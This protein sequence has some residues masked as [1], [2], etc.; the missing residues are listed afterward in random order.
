MDQKIK[1]EGNVDEDPDE[2]IPEEEKTKQ[3]QK[4][5]HPLLCLKMKYDTWM[6]EIPVIG[7][8]SGNY[9]INLIKP[10]LIKVL[11]TSDP[12]EF[13]VKKSNAFICLKTK[14]LR[15][16]DIRNY[17]A[18][19]FN[20]ATYLKA[21]KCEVTKGFFPYEWMD[22]LDKLQ[23]T[24]LPTHE[25]FFS[26]LKNS[27]I[28]EDEYA[29]CENVWTEE[30][31]KT[32][33][34]YLM[35]YN[36][37]DVAPFM[38][39]LQKQFDFYAQLGL[40][41][42]KDGMSVPGLT[43][44]YLFKT[45]KSAT[46]TLFDRHN[47]DLHDLIRQNMVGGPSIIFHRYHEAGV[48]KL[49]EN[50]YH[51][52]ADMCEAIVGYD[53]NAL[54]LWCLMQNMPTGSYIRR[55]ADDQ[56]KPHQ[57]DS[58]GK[59]ASQWLDWEATQSK[60]MI[61]HKYNGKEKRIGQRCL[62]VDGWCT[63]TN[64][65]YQFHGCY[66]HGHDCVAMKS[67]TENKTKNK[68][69]AELQAETVNNSLYIKKCG[70]NLVEMWEC[71][72]KEM[73]KKNAELKEFLKKLRRPNDFRRQMTEQQI[74]NGVRNDTFFGLVECDIEV[75][76][77]LR[78]HFSE[79]API[80]KNINISLNDIGE[81]MRDYAIENKLMSQPRRSLIGSYIGEKVLLAT[82][83][84]KWY[85]DHGLTVTKIYQVAEYQPK[86]CF[87]Q[88]G[89]NVSQAR[90]NGDSDPDQAIIADTMKLLGNSGYGKTITNKDIQR[91]IYYCDENEASKKVNE[92][93]FRQ[94]NVMAED[95]YE[96]EMSK[97][98]ITYDLPLHI[99]FF[100]YQ[101]AKLR[102]LAFYYDFLDKYLDRHH[103]QYVEMDTDSAYVAIAGQSIEELVKP[104]L[105]QDFYQNW[106]K[107]LPAEACSL[108][109]EKFLKVKLRGESW[110]PG[111]CC[112]KQKKFDKR[113]PGLFKIEW[114][115]QGMV[116]LC[117]KTYY[118]WGSQK[119]KCS[120]KGI[121][122]KHNELDQKTF[123]EVLTTKQSAGGVNV[124]FR[125]H[126]N[127]VYTYKQQRHALSYLYPKREVLS[128]GITTIP[129]SI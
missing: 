1:L 14:R 53:A 77:H 13:I 19:G 116:G 99:G 57:P 62:P 33:E 63:E 85:L 88:F 79:M 73:K 66:W 42:F 128:D 45:S 126:N 84:L 108:H 34:D 6:T 2:I 95:M 56:F 96:F 3:H 124:G 22:N 100:V 103:Y 98:V 109:Q 71:E 35:W 41:M 29:Y 75:P 51:E 83:L 121:S 90:P 120:T 61:R 93:Q 112:V 115:G 44:K 25:Q 114:Q 11:L 113:T 7:F 24:E 47:N 78:K 50:I 74:L 8:N 122:K 48:T 110:N 117:S 86:A 107:W 31:M 18:P 105:K 127:T 81:M 97:K 64:T 80:F 102:M 89:E 58:F 82:P 15:F 26:N 69:M 52:K 10:Y 104:H 119:D 87:Q 27:N 65:V 5:I 91:D 30:N 12:I 59:M 38:E 94:L 46:F 54:Y 118:G 36:N 129:L 92:P 49:R 70:Y 60:K 106:Y 21:Y 111:E 23:K 55:K 67:V 68:T 28:T 9:D 20:Y 40:D 123:L 76:Q 72:W 4:K 32:F 37:R 43:L 39:A 101:Y 125:V 17:I 16:L